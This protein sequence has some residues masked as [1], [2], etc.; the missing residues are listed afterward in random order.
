MTVQELID[1]LQEFP[2]DAEVSILIEVGSEADLQCYNPEPEYDENQ[3][4][5]YL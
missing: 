2:K 5:V 1:K 4:K 3:N